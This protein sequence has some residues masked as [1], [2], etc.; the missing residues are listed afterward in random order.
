MFPELEE[1][2]YKVRELVLK[3]TTHAGSGHPGGSL[4]ATDLLVALYF[5]KMN[6][7]HLSSPE[8]DRFI[9]SKGHACP[10]LYAVLALK[11]F[12]PEKE[13]FTLRK[14]NS[15][16][17][18]HPELITP[19]VEAPTGAEGHGLSIGNGI[20][21]AGKLDKLNYR[22][23]VLLGDG[24]LDEGQIW[25]AALTASHYKLDNLVAIVDRN[26]FQLDGATKDI[27]YLGDVGEKFKAFGWDVIEIDGHNFEQILDAL[28]EAEEAK[29]MPTAII[30][31]TIKG[32]GVS[33]MENNDEFHGKVLTEEQL[34]KALE[35]LE[36]QRRKIK[37]AK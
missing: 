20:A 31:H 28:D 30:A 35:E 29:E 3:M 6:I 1:I 37:E 7:P 4:S 23:Y 14:L 5:K 26:S 13:L 21:L 19:G 24:E 15:R 2:S 11:E 36:K 8:R 10:A 34:K 32:K 33:F 12:F 16:L 22:V 27:K 9:L 18:G 25:E 17:Q